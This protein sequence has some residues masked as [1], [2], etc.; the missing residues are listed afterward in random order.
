MRRRSD[1]RSWCED[2]Y[3]ITPVREVRATI[4]IGR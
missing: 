3:T 2:L 1:V 4:I